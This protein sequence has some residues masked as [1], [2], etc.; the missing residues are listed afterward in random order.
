MSRSSSRLVVP[1]CIL[2]A[3]VIGVRLLLSWGVPA[4]KA[5]SSSKTAAITNSGGLIFTIGNFTGC[6]FFL[7]VPVSLSSTTDTRLVTV[8][9]TGTR[10]LL[11]VE[12]GFEAEP[13]L[14]VPGGQTQA[15]VL[16]SSAF[17]DGFSG[18]PGLGVCS[19]NVGSGFASGTVTIQ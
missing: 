4:A 10:D 6:N 1:F 3:T 11:L 5:A 15:A 13:F 12:T 16:P 7:S 18:S 17:Y 2:T 9:S 14:H 8:T 19:S